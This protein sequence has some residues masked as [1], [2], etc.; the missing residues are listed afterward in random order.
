MRVLLGVIR[1]PKHT[2]AS[3]GFW[4]LTDIGISDHS[5][6]VMYLLTGQKPAKIEALKVRLIWES[7][8]AFLHGLLSIGKIEV[9]FV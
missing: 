6:E 2:F 8:W 9:N 5:K 1:Y 4:L 7:N 3:M